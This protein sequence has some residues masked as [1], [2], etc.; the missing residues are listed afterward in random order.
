MGLLDEMNS[1]LS[2]W[3]T[4]ETIILLSHRDHPISLQE[5]S[6]LV[7]LCNNSEIRP[8]NLIGQKRE[9]WSEIQLSVLTLL[10]RRGLI[11]MSGLVTP[12]GRDQ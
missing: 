6:I 10:P 11:K 1:Y 12:Q 3:I 4:N 2:C 9:G 8:R 5:L 7:L